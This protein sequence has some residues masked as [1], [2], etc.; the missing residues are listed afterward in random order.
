MSQRSRRIDARPACQHRVSD[1]R[2]GW[3]SLALTRAGIEADPRDRHLCSDRSIAFAQLIRQFGRFS[4]ITHPLTRTQY[5]PHS[6]TQT[7]YNAL[8]ST[9]SQTHSLHAPHVPRAHSHAHAHAHTRTPTDTILPCSASLA[10]TRPGFAIT[11]AARVQQTAR[12]RNEGRRSPIIILDPSYTR[13]QSPS[14][15]CKSFNLIQ[16]ISSSASSCTLH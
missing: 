15:P 5:N 2:R 16:F 4:L 6:Q 12:R 14:L 3:L 1:A 11:S 13:A 10:L 8:T 9:H 7:Q